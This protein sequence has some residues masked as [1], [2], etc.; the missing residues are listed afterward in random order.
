MQNKHFPSFSGTA[1]IMVLL[2]CCA[3]VPTYADTPSS[4]HNANAMWV[5]PESISVTPSMV[6]QLFNVTVWLNITQDIY[7]WQTKLFFNYT[8]FNCTNAGYTA[9]ITSMY[10]LG[11]SVTTAIWINNTAGAVLV[12]EICKSPTDFIAGPRNDTLFWAEFIIL[13]VPADLNISHEYGITSSPYTWVVASDGVTLLPLIPEFS[14]ILLLLALMAATAGALIVSKRMSRKR[15]SILYAYSSS[16][17]SPRRAR[18]SE[19]T[20]RR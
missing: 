18:S 9:D 7:A 14:T 3:I 5:E 2:I 13:S 19:T 8:L 20:I 16:S 10:F 17:N 6:G 15:R 4:T 11:H 12:Y 1:T